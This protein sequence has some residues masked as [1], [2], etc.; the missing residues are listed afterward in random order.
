MGNIYTVY[1]D[2]C[3]CQH[4]LGKFWDWLE[5]PKNEAEGNLKVWTE[6]SEH[7]HD[8]IARHNGHRIGVW[9]ENEVESE[10]RIEMAWD[11]NGYRVE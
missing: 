1:C 7:L 8:F 9:H 2:D 6:R 3:K 11:G 4:D 5:S 10:R